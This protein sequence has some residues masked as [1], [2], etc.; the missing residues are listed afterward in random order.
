MARSEELLE[1]VRLPKIIVG[2]NDARV[3]SPWI[4]IKADSPLER[5]GFCSI[6]KIKVESEL[7]LHLPLPLLT[8]RGRGQD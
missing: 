5:M 2:S 4:G 8:E 3:G 7:G 1:N 6:N